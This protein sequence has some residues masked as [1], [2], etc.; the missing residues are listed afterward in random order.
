[1]IERRDDFRFALKAREPIH[2]AGDRGG[3]HLDRHR[4]L[5]IVVGGAIDLAHAAGADGG[6]DLVRAESSASGH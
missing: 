3:Q 6:D 1:V 2:I 5:Q 4:P